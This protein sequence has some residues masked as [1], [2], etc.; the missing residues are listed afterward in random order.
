MGRLLS[1]ISS[2]IHWQSLF[3][4]PPPPAFLLLV[5]TRPGPTPVPLGLF[6]FLCVG[7]W[8]CPVSLPASSRVC[9]AAR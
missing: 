1:P 2:R 9:C 6:C 5:E 3:S 7:R 8:G 4:F